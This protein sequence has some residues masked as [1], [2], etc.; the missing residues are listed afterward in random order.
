MIE[1]APAS[2][3]GEYFVRNSSVTKS[4]NETTND[5]KRLL[6]NIYFGLWWFFFGEEIE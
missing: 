4:I 3:I 6:L 5:I 1:R 2:S